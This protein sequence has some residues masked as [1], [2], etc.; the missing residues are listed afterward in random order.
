MAGKVVKLSEVEQ[1]R[2]VREAVKMVQDIA[3]ANA[4]RLFK[5]EVNSTDRA[6]LVKEIIDATIALAL[7]DAQLPASVVRQATKQQSVLVT[8]AMTEAG[9]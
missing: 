2:K 8:E 3:A 6:D 4:R 9:F 1:A 7:H 5:S